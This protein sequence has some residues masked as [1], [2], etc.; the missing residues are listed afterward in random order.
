MRTTIRD[1]ILLVAL[2]G[3]IFGADQVSKYLVLTRLSFGESWSPVPGLGR[4]ISVTHVVNPGAAFGLFP[5]QGSLFAVIAVVVVVA[6][7]IYYRY[8]PTQ[9]WLV[10]LSLGLQLGGALGNLADRLQHG[11]VIDFMD[12]K[13]WPVFNL[14]DVAIVT[15]VGILAYFLL[16][17]PD[18]AGPER[19]AGVTSGS[20]EA[21]ASRY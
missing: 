13:I 5:D 6:I 14:A 4:Y 7:L 17:E 1:R 18:D 8:L 15:G 11:H 3:F 16:Q 12:F 19:P 9:I 10:R 20:G 21:S 2:A